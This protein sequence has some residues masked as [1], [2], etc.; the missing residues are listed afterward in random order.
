MFSSGVVAGKKAKKT[1]RK[2]WAVVKMSKKC[3]GRKIVVSK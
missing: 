2:F 3:Y 1:P